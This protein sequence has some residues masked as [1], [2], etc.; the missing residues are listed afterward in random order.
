MGS[1]LYF[2]YRILTLDTEDGTI[3]LRDNRYKALHRGGP[4]SL[5]HHRL[6]AM[7]AAACAEH[8]LHLFAAQRPADQRPRQAIDTAR[9]WARGECRVGEARAA[10]VAAHAAAREVEE[11]AARLAARA[12]GHA[13]ATAHMADHAPGAA[14]YA[15]RAVKAAAVKVDEKAV[16][17]QEHGWQSEQLPSAIRDLVL[18]TFK[19]KFS[20]LNL[21]LNLD[22][23]VT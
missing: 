13:V 21:N 12:A 9:A 3:D 19:T 1:P 23:D 8:V 22:K 7:W 4:L 2:K 18:S 15:I 14:M 5:D 17:Q 10:S 16:A 20:F 11:G 6:L